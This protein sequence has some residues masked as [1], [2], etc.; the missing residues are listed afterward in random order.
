MCHFQAPATT[1]SPTYIFSTPEPTTNSKVSATE[2]TTTT[3]ADIAADAMDKFDMTVPDSLELSMSMDFN[4]DMSMI[5][6]GFEQFDVDFE[7]SMSIST[8]VIVT[9]NPSEEESEEP[10]SISFDTENT[11]DE[12]LTEPSTTIILDDIDEMV[13]LS[14]ETD[15]TM[16]AA[17][18]TIPGVITTPD[19]ATKPFA[20]MND[21]AKTICSVELSDELL[22]EYQLLDGAIQVKMSYDGIAWLGFGFSKDGSMVGSEAVM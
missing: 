12:S 4:D 17:E 6:E 19:I 9:D 8:S 3:D 5:F 14:S 21:C 16:V 22:M 7:F 13:P 1:T 2:P 18:T 10:F 15:A 20:N 11:A